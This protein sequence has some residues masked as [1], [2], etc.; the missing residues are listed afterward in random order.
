MGTKRNPFTRRAALARLAG[1]GGLTA[2]SQLGALPGVCT[3]GSARAA[4]AHAADAEVPI[5]GKAAPGLEPFDDAVLGIMNHHGVVGASLAIA[6]DGKLALAK[7]Y[8]WMDTE[9]SDPVEPDALFGLAS[10]S[11]PFTAVG[12]L[13]LVEQGKFGLDDS[14]FDLL[15]NIKSP[16]GLKSDPRL[17]DIT[18]RQCLNHS[19][20]WDRHITGDSTGW[21]LPICR[22]LRARPPV[23]AEQFISFTRAVPLAFKPGDRNEYSNVG[24]VLLGELI[25]RYSGQ[26]YER[27]IKEKVMK[28]IGIT[29]MDL[30]RYDGKYLAKEARRHLSGI[31][32]SLPPVQLPMIDPSGGWSGSAI[33]LVRFLSNIEGSLGKPV[34]SEKS[35]KL[36]LEP[37]PEPIKPRDDGTYFGLGWDDAIMTDKGFAYSKEGSLPGIR[38]FMR[39]TADGVC[40]ALLM[41][42]GMDF[43]TSDK[44]VFA[45]TLKEVHKLLENFEKH[46]DVDFFGDYR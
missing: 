11:K 19:G 46:P 35:R 15:K 43:D 27:F 32:T 31:H 45:K 2:A 20:G 10:A 7:G 21:E 16:R 30:H 29:R 37:P 6:A 28:P 12:V 22:L 33:D 42:T 38:T 17:S 8:G 24:F 3:T 44:Q 9:G 23:T 34:L 39:R 13:L 25:S 40:T 26:P 36:M 4:E 18:V 41:N 14:V 5:R 1:I